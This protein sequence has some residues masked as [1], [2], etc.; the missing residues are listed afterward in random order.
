MAPNLVV[1][2]ESWL[3]LSKC[4]VNLNQEKQQVF[5]RKKHEHEFYKPSLTNHRHSIS[6]FYSISEHH[7]QQQQKEQASRQHLLIRLR[8]QSYLNRSSNSLTS[9]L[10]NSIDLNLSPH[11]GTQ[12][13]KPL[14]LEQSSSK[15]LL[16]RE[17][18]RLRLLRDKLKFNGRQKTCSSSNL[19][20]YGQEKQHLAS[21]SPVVRSISSFSDRLNGKLSH[22]RHSWKHFLHNYN[23]PRDDDEPNAPASDK[24]VYDKENSK[25]RQLDKN[26]EMLA[27]Y[28]S[29]A[30]RT[31]LNKR[32]FTDNWIRKHHGHEVLER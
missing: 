14:F 31:E 11:H 10:S 3:D 17:S 23:Q 6:N 27:S 9:N 2:S 25:T 5:V 19:S 29:A 24:F 8:Q 26:K 21:S 4:Q 22:L 18:H 20:G 30:S 12:S 16:K 1:K 13:E 7:E 32:Q 15:P 28:S